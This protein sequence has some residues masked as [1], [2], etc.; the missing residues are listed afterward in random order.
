MNADVPA[1]DEGAS[2]DEQMGV[3]RCADC[4][5]WWALSPY[6][7]AHCGGV[8][9]V[10]AKVNGRGVVRAHSDIARAPD[11]RWRALLPYTL[12]LVQLEEG[13]TVMGHLQGAAAMG[14]RVCVQRVRLS[15]GTPVWQF[16]A[17]T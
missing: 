6:A 1:H 11:D 3:L 2:S 7:C 17:M 16:R 12:V 4:G 14:D 5:T 10:P 8:N 13:P 9:L 15:D